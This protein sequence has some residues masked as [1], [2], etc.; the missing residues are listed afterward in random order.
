V[1]TASTRWITDETDETLAAGLERYREELS[2]A[3]AKRDRRRSEDMPWA[4]AEGM[5]RAITAE[6][7]RRAKRCER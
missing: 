3:P 5:I 7:E 4:L 1:R 2:H 6:Q